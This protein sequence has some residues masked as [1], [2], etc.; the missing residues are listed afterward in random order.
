M[1][2]D[3]DV[4]IVGAGPVGTT[5]ALELAL[6]RVSF[7]IIDQEP[8]RTNQSRALV[9]QPRTLE[10]LNR[11]GAADTIVG[12]GR[13]LRGA[14]TFINKEPVLRLV[15]DDL[16]T[17][18]TEFPLP[19]NVSQAV[20]EEFLE[21]CLSKYDIGVERPLTATHIAQDESG[22]TTT[23]RLPDGSTDTIRSKYVVGCDGAHSVVRHASQNIAF[24]GGPYPQDFI[25]C[26]V[27]LRDSNIDQD[28]IILHLNKRG[29]L[30]TLPINS[31]LI[32]IIAS[33]ADLTADD[34][35]D[36]PTLEEVQA[37]FTAMTPPGS[38]VLRS[39][40]WLTRFRLHHR[41]V[42]QYRDARLFV[43][44]DAAHIHSPAGGQ[45]MN[46]GIQDAINLGWKLAHALS[47]QS[48]AQPLPPSSSSPSSWSPSSLQ[49][50]ASA[51][52][53]TYDLE[54]RPVGYAL[55]KGTDRIFAF[56]WSRNP[57]FV[58]LRNFFLR[59]VMYRV[60][61]SRERRRRAF[62]F[63]SQ[64]G[65]TY[66][67]TS[68]IVGEAAGWKGPIRGGD[69]VPDGKVARMFGDGGKRETSLQRVCVGAP[70]HLLLF[71]GG[72]DGGKGP[73][74]K[75]E[76]LEAAAESAVSACKTPLRVHY[77]L[78]SSSG[79]GN[80][81]PV[82]ER[83]LEEGE[84][85]V[86]LDGNLHAEFGFGKTAGYVLVRPDGYVAHIGP[87]AKLDQ[88]VSFLEGYLVSASSE[89]KMG[90]MFEENPNIVQDG[91]PE[92]TIMPWTKKPTPLVLIHDG[93]GTIFSY[94][95][96]GDLGRPVFGIANPNYPSGESWVGGIPEMARRYIEFIKLAVPRGD[97]II[98][99]WSMGGL[100]SL[101]VARQLADERDCPLNLLGIVMV[102]SVCPLVLAA[103]FMTVVQHAIEWGEHTRQETKDRVMRCFSEAHRMVREWTLPVWGE[104]E[105]N[106]N[107]QVE[108]RQGNGF[109]T[110]WTSPRPP[111]VVLLRATDPV[112]LPE[113]VQEGVSAVDINRRD[114][115]LGWG[116]YRRDLITKVM[117]IPGHHFSIF[118]T[119]ETLETTT[120][121]IK[122]ACR[123]LEA[124]NGNHSLQ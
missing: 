31:E 44:G 24:P 27:R 90:S 120:E 111:P 21:E 61:Q 69:R 70:H 74:V 60:V 29:V 118:H 117:D 46:A 14:Q 19:L 32:R 77:I 54:R 71:A 3:C 37:Y 110:T 123:E 52:L 33:R 59:H 50:A 107:G 72:A 91:P 9:I 98:G 104:E 94:Y 42:N 56:I 1:A 2:H 79:N 66:R 121:G 41:C 63:I 101:E 114:P 85:Y 116:K 82:V 11:H 122:W 65:I 34:Q 88:F 67:G 93:G 35:Q 30:A 49:A 73:A 23:V 109:R 76:Q 22:V 108:K 103:P 87:L 8:A 112:P 115:L 78:S 7:R 20:T 26:D 12:R 15:L 57:L 58:L 86:D 17:T 28:H 38:G 97:L 16:G 36:A 105:S 100:I 6:H 92:H 53:D 119:E 5:L 64:F 83:G 40:E 106:T 51:V 99:G 43:A 55:L 84:W 81:R 124:L 45:G 10:L 89:I 68:R 75:G 39:P 18:N 96:L 95:C 62:L 4:L 13:I 102:D 48:Q 113:G 80:G 25:L 47:L